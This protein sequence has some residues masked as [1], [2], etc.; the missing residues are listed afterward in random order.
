[1]VKLMD[2]LFSYFVLLFILTSSNPEAPLALHPLLMP[3]FQI[4]PQYIRARSFLAK[5]GVL[6]VP[7]ICTTSRASIHMQFDELVE[8]FHLASRGEAG[9]IN[10]SL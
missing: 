4:H 1:M 6:L 9:S 2:V 3:T 10:A 8:L 7:I 5:H